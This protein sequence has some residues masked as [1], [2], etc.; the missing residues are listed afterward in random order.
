MLA[1][2]RTLPEAVAWPHFFRWFHL[3]ETGDLQGMKE[4]LRDF[5][6]KDRGK[7]LL[8]LRAMNDLG[9][10]AQIWLQN[11]RRYSAPTRDQDNVLQ[12]CRFVCYEEGDIR[13]QW[14]DLDYALPKGPVVLE[15]LQLRKPEWFAEVYL[16]HLL[17]K[18]FDYATGIACE[19]AGAPVFTPA[20]TGQEL[21]WFL[22]STRSR[23]QDMQALYHEYPEV[24]DRDIWT[25]FSEKAPSL[26]G[27]P[28]ATEDYR[29]R[30]YALYNAWR[31]SPDPPKSPGQKIREILGQPE[32]EPYSSLAMVVADG[33][34]LG[35][36]ERG[37]V[38]R[39]CL[40][41]ACRN[42]EKDQPAGFADF[43]T[44]LAP[45]QQEL[46]AVQ[47]ELIAVLACPNSKPVTAALKHIKAIAAHKD[48]NRDAF[49]AALPVLTC[50]TIKSLRTAA[51]AA[52]E[53]L[54]QKAPAARDGLMRAITPIFSVPDETTQVR[55]A[56]LLTKFGDPDNASL[57]DE[58]AAWRDSVT[59]AAK[60]LL[61][62]FLELPA[63][64]EC[65]QASRIGDP[66]G[67]PAS[68]GVRHLDESMRITLPQMLDDCLF[69]LAEAFGN[70]AEY[71]C[72]L[73]PDA[74]FAVRD[75]LDDNSLGRLGPAIAA[76]RKVVCECNITLKV[77]ARTTA[78]HFLR[79]CI[80]RLEAAPDKGLNVLKKKLPQIATES[81]STYVIF[82]WDTY[83]KGYKKFTLPPLHTAFY[84]L[85]EV[86]QA[87]FAR[88][89]TGDS[90][91]M[92]SSITHA[93]CW[94]DPLELIER[95]L[96]WQQA[97]RTP[98]TMDMQLALQRCARENVRAALAASQALRGEYK[99]LLE[100]FLGDENA[101]PEVPERHEEWWIA[102]ALMR[103]ERLVPP[104]LVAAE[105]AEIPGEYLGRP[106][107]WKL[108][109]LKTKR[110][111]IEKEF[112]TTAEQHV[113]ILLPP[114]KPLLSLM[115]IDAWEKDAASCAW[116]GLFGGRMFLT[117]EVYL[118]QQALMLYPNNPEP[119]V[120]DIIA[121]YGREKYWLALAVF[122]KLLELRVPQGPASNLFLALG[123]LAGAKEPRLHAAA[124]WRAKVEEGNIN[125]ADPGRML[126]RLERHKWVPTK[127][128]TELVE[129]EMMAVS[130][131]HSTELAA[132]LE[133]ML[134][135]IGPEPQVNIKRLLELYYELTAG[136]SRTMHAALP[137][138]F[139]FWEKEK[140]CAACV[141]KLRGL[142][143]SLSS[144]K[145]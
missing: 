15:L 111:N 37:R 101:L 49:M 47:D 142:E 140:T 8:L 25:L 4:M 134:I 24:F 68:G 18:G 125:S 57:R 73:V 32:L 76:A 90:L 79:Y 77:Q 84:S 9:R 98:G 20:A 91:P 45:T 65:R 121:G 117:N 135:E 145:A 16:H 75:Q 30:A 100:Y 89:R 6:P 78:L 144:L 93:P 95:L 67:I 110:P 51:L 106:F 41:G 29:R 10:Q 102:A 11:D 129:Q 109:P 124:F 21:G 137:P 62:G 128:F 54:A 43:F 35:K 31:G 85:N 127:R 118:L 39:E 44:A 92:L 115:D 7:V 28:L 122:E 60:D 34:R 55:A 94:I 52:T 23:L 14:K 81:S 119:V 139:G 86:V 27:D 17:G 2:I 5:S 132:M 63:A 130:P 48:F 120:M 12:V 96:L 13:K 36:L 143:E 116:S 53:E 82:Y 141:K 33:I 88:L 99:A 71:H 69:M 38:L 104:E 70:P 22:R 136:Q 72:S 83:N 1:Y 105:Y 126:G 19:R 59:V 113:T 80:K 42:L 138:L 3:F 131:L 66:S 50:S 108:S 133:A 56:K 58:I 61:G 97:G 87:A 64:P 107:E 40:L 26:G 112:V 123:L 114:G 103:P 74:L 46:L